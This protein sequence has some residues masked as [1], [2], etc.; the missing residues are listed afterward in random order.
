MIHNDR[1]R[2]TLADSQKEKAEG[3]PAISGKPKNDLFYYLLLV[4]VLGAVTVIRWRFVDMPLERDEGEYAYFGQLIRAGVPPYVQAYNMKLPGACYMYALIM[5]FLGETCRGIHIG[6]C[7]MNA[8]T[9]LLLFFSFRKFYNPMTGILVCSLYGLMAMSVNVLGFAAHATHFAIFFVSLALFFF[10]KYEE[11]KATWFAA[12]AGGMFGTAFLMKQHAVYFIL[13]GGAVLVVFN[14]FDRSLN[15]RKK[16]RDALA[17]SI[18]V[19]VPYLL[20]VAVALSSGSFAQFWFWTVQYAGK[21]ASGVPWYYGEQLLN[22]TFTPIWRETHWIW[23]LAIAGGP[24]LLLSPYSRKQKVL[25]LGFAGFSALATSP[26][27]YFRTHYFVLVLPAVALLAAIALDSLGRLVGG[28]TKSKLAQ[29]GVPLFVFILLFSGI[30]SKQKSYYWADNPVQLCKTIYGTNPFNESV[31][32]ARYIQ[33]HS[34]KTDTIAVLGSEPEIPF[35]AHRWS[36]TGYIYMYGLME[37]QEYNVKMQEQMI[38]EIEKNKPLYLVYCNI[39]YS[40]LKKLYSPNEI[41]DWYDKYSSA[42]YTVVGLVDIPEQGSSSIYWDVDA[43]RQPRNRNY[44]WILRRRTT[45]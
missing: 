17:F 15:F 30:L 5:T 44:M 12:L 40:W 33:A 8:G 23:R 19:F 2:S 29:V 18:S 6:F 36:A 1:T 11:N 10:S 3:H 25:A 31:D 7:I 20:V 32:V 35:Y 42:N 21:Y 16:I 9:M 43:R 24:I 4:L 14:W 34:S 22:F 26:G 41:F 28:W 27:F 13:F 39:S 38:A 37:N 45:R